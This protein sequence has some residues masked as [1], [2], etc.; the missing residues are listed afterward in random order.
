MTCAMLE[1]HTSRR[2]APAEQ[3]KDAEARER[4]HS[5][6]FQPAPFL[7]GVA[8]GAR[9]ESSGLPH[10]RHVGRFACGLERRRRPDTSRARS[11][12]WV[13]LP[14]PPLSRG[15]FYYA[16]CAPIQ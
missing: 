10:D 6:A 16:I 8:N 5:A 3:A 12:S 1:R 7:H 15:T 4:A 11:L 2:G 14:G 9:D 13:N